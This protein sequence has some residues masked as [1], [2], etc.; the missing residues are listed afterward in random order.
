MND[1]LS[2]AVAPSH[3]DVEADVA[4]DV[5]AEVSPD[6]NMTI[7]PDMPTEFWDHS[8]FDIAWGV[9]ENYQMRDKLGTSRAALLSGTLNGLLIGPTGEGEYSEVF[10]GVDLVNDQD[11]VVKVLKPVKKRRVK[12]EIKILQE[13]RNGPNI[14]GLLDV[15]RDYQNKTPSLV[16]EYVNNTYHRALYPTFDDSDVRYYI[17]R[18]LEALEYSH[19]KGIMHRDVKPHN[20]MIDHAARKVMPLKAL[21]RP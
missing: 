16:F 3:A 13:L 19:S 1:P 4:A 21:C 6:L 20:V 9:L 18:L 17:F 7:N 11:C 14:V 15:A 12:R 8:T 2:P 10:Q 5:N